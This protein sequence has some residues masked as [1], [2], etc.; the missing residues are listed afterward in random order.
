MSSYFYAGYRWLP[1]VAIMAVVAGCN[2]P[3][4][5]TVI[6][7]DRVSI[8]GHGDRIRKL[9]FAP[10]GKMLAS[11]SEDGTVKIWDTA[12]WQ[13]VRSIEGRAESPP[14]VMA[15]RYSSDG[16]KLAVGRAGGPFQLCDDSG[17]VVLG[18]GGDQEHVWDIA[19]SPDGKHIATVRANFV[20]VWNAETG[21]RAKSIEV[22]DNQLW[23]VAYSPDSKWV[24]TGGFEPDVVRITNVELGTPG[25]TLKGFRSFAGSL[26]FFPDGKTIATGGDFVWLHDP[27]NGQ[28][29]AMLQGHNAGSRSV[30]ISADGARL[31]SAGGA[32]DLRVWDL[33]AKKVLATYWGSPREELWSVALSPDGKTIVSGSAKGTLKVWDM[34]K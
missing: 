10:S 4:D 19:F 7:K 17:K 20:D 6:R 31:V 9:S 22:S 8:I 5:G 16:K 33:A 23:C 15:V 28:E 25:Q 14:K 1:M 24:A 21:A 29:K 26:A 34:V 32:G 12:T 11:G 30:A 3:S 27:T 18:L 2:S 13:L